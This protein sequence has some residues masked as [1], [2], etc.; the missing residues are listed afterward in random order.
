MD[1]ISSST[2][3]HAPRQHLASASER[4]PPPVS[5]CTQ[6]GTHSC[7]VASRL[8]CARVAAALLSPPNRNRAPASS[9]R[10]DSAPRSS[11][12]AL[13]SL[14]SSLSSSSFSSSSTSFVSAFP[15]TPAVLSVVLLRLIRSHA[16]V[17]A[18]LSYAAAKDSSPKDSITAASSPAP[19]PFSSSSSSSSSA[20]AGASVPPLPPRSR[21]SDPP[22]SSQTA[23]TRDRARSSDPP[24][25]PSADAYAFIA[26]GSLQ[27]GES[28]PHGESIFPEP[29]SSSSPPVGLLGFTSYHPANRD[30]R[31]VQSDRG[32][33][34]ADLNALNAPVCDAGL[35]S[36]LVT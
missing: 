26:P 6:L 2:R 8:A 16:N 24:R 29:S 5:A 23:A 12:V 19:S 1:I 27:P 18:A 31:S 13:A 3:S 28:L 15:S 22:V 10:K 36:S 4:S 25:A 14:A 34:G 35:E 11:A 17:R 7:D 30:A 21:I 33:A 20:P 32:P 9:S